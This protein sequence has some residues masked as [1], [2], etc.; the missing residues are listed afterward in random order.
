MDPN[1]AVGVL[2]VYTKIPIVAKLYH[3]VTARNDY[4]ANFSIFFLFF[5]LRMAY[6]QN[7]TATR[8]N[9]LIKP[10]H[11]PVGVVLDKQNVLTFAN[12]TMLR[13]LKPFKH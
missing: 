3:E 5:F 10:F 1:L 12:V 7:G 11:Y 6:I 2:L 13:L 4:T 9:L 8:V